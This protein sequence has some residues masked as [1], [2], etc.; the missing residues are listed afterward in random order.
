MVFMEDSER[1]ADVAREVGLETGLHL[2]FTSVFTHRR[3]PRELVEHQTRLGTFLLSRRFSKVVLHPVLSKS[4]DY[5]VKAQIDEYERIFG[6]RPWKFDGH[7]HMHLCANVMMQGLLP[8]GTLVRRNFS[9]GSDE[10][11]IL[12]R[13]YRKYM[14]AALARNHVLTDYFFSLPPLKPEARLRRIFELSRDSAVEVETHPVNHEEFKFLMN[15]GLQ[16]YGVT[17]G[18][19]SMLMPTLESSPV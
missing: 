18:R 16:S 6:T 12:N 14:D 8:A 5:V 1:A 15:G 4:F 19:P 17:A 11:N 13:L 2:N 3:C 7:H 9:F 10:K